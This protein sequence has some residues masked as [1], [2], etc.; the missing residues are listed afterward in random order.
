[1]RTR[2]VDACYEETDAVGPLAVVLR[3]GL[4][5]VADGGYEAFERDGAAV[6]EA[7]AEGLLLHEV[8]EDAGVGGETGEGEP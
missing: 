5:A 8:G 1:M 2:L 6:G 4:G 7:G 3:V